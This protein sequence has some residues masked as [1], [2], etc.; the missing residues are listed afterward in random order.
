MSKKTEKHK[1]I[2]GVIHVS[3]VQHYIW[4][5][6]DSIWKRCGK[7]SRLSFRKWV[8]E[9]VQ[10]A[11]LI[12]FLRVL[13]VLQFLK[14][15]RLGQKKANI[16]LFDCKWQHFIDTHLFGVLSLPRCCYCLFGYSNVTLYVKTQHFRICKVSLTRFGSM[17]SCFLYVLQQALRKR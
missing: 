5:Y 9:E 3:I 17:L 2:G 11:S 13:Q 7:L 1:S 15:N 16:S 10:R 4:H 6:F 14:K 12:I 8:F